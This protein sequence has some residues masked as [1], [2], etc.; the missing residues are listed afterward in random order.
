MFHSPKILISYHLCARIAIKKPYLTAKNW[1]ARKVWANQ[2]A[3]LP[4]IFWQKV[5]FLDKTNLELHSNKRVLARPLPN[6]GMEKR[7]IYRK[8]ESFVGKK[9]MPKGFFCPRLSEMSPK[10][11]WN[12]KINQVFADFE[13]KSIAENVFVRKIAAR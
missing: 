11:L 4:K 6:T 5:L 10:S 9:L 13:R 8:P 12:D 7:R 1:L 3:I 2:R